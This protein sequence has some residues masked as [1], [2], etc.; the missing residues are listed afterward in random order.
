M[1]HMAACVILYWMSGGP[2][3]SSVVKMVVVRNISKFGLLMRLLISDSFILTK[4]FLQ[5]NLLGHT[6]LH[7]RFLT[8]LRIIKYVKYFKCTQSTTLCK[9]S[10]ACYCY[11]YFS[12]LNFTKRC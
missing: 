5:K 1:L 4:T 2:G 6:T 11:F 8:K 12:K 10:Y 7:E 9:F 3:G